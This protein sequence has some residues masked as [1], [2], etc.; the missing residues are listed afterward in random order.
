MGQRTTKA[1]RRAARSRFARGCRAWGIARTARLMREDPDLQRLPLALMMAVPPEL[2][3]AVS[4]G[5]HWMDH[6]PFRGQY[7]PATGEVFDAPYN[8][9][10]PH[11]IANVMPGI[12]DRLYRELL[13]PKLEQVGVDPDSYTVAFTASGTSIDAYT[14]PGPPLPYEPPA[15]LYATDW[16]WEPPT[17]LE[18]A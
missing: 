16:T 18:E 13:R 1:E 15:A 4:V 6:A 2:V 10:L 3:A 7:W 17:P 5:N 9:R 11:P 14:M 12:L 8:E